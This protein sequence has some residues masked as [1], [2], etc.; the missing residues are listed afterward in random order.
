VGGEERRDVLTY[1]VIVGILWFILRLEARGLAS[2]APES[3]GPSTFDIR[4]GARVIRVPVEAITAATA[5]GN[6]VEFVLSDGRRPLMRATLAAV[7]A[8]LAP[9]GFVRTHRA[10][11]VNR[12]AVTGLAPAGSGDR[13]I[14]LAGGLEAPLSRRHRK[15]AEA[16]GGA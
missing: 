12:A 10:W 15:A 5:A 2:S 8:A 11:L 14:T 16:L 9:H 7:E 6:Y 4:D 13:I 3:G 1:G